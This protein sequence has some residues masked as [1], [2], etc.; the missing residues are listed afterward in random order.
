L[1]WLGQSVTLYADDDPLWDGLAR[2][3]DQDEFLAKSGWHLPAALHAEVSDGTKLTLFLVALRGFV[4]QA[5]PGMTLWEN[6][7]DHDQ[8][9]GRL[10]QLIE[11]GTR[12][13]YR[14][15]L[16]RQ[17]WANL[18]I[19][20]EWKHRFP[21]RDPQALYEQVFHTRLIDPAG[22]AYTW[23]EQWQTMESSTFGHPG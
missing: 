5:A 17:A 12:N 21:E 16:R 1:G 7:T 3:D 23:N 8:A 22:G 15:F 18:S 2:A 13:T 6:R 11:E 9:R 20:N 19:L 14:A 4:E 10:L